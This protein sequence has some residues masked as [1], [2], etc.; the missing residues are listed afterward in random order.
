MRKLSLFVW[1]IFLT[2]CAV[3]PDNSSPDLPTPATFKMAEAEQQDASLQIIPQT[4]SPQLREHSVNK[5]QQVSKITGLSLSI[6]PHSRD[7]TS[8][9]EIHSRDTQTLDEVA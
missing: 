6:T 2:A 3:G 5:A 9:R 8:G 1:S 7:F 4:I